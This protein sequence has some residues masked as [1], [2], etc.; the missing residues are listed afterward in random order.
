MNI[1]IRYKRVGA[2]RIGASNHV[3]HL[4]GSKTGKLPDNFIAGVPHIKH[5][6]RSHCPTGAS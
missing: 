3:G 1:I 5:S 2:V 4:D 6:V